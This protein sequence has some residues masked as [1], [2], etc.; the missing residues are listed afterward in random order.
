MMFT[1]SDIASFLTL[2]MSFSHHSLINLIRNQIATVQYFLNLH[3][4]SKKVED[5]KE[6]LEQLI[7]AGKHCC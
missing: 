1:L 5:V 2:P 6:E 7:A 4:A 3:L